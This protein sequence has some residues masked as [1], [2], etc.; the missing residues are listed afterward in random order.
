[1][2][3]GVLVIIAALL[4]VIVFLLI[5]QNQKT[6]AERAADNIGEAVEGVIREVENVAEE[7]EGNR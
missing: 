2:K 1:M 6:P 5:Q 7:I 3:T 4:G